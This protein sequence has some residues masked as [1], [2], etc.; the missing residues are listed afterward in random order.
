VPL[1]RHA[2]VEVEAALPG[3]WAWVRGCAR[4]AKVG[5]ILQ[6][7]ADA[8][9]ADSGDEEEA[10]FCGC[11]RNG[12]RGMSG[13]STG[14]RCNSEMISKVHWLSDGVGGNVKTILG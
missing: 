5:R 2:Q 12:G 11:E 7:R 3:R 8:A 14:D 13:H 9:E 10:G 6:Q 1:R 4:S